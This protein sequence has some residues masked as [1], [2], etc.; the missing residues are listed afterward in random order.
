MWIR[1]R[2]VSSLPCFESS[3]TLTLWLPYLTSV[4]EIIITCGCL[5]SHEAISG[6]FLSHY[7]LLLISIDL[8]YDTISCLS[9]EAQN[10]MHETKFEQRNSYNI[11]PLKSQ[12]TPV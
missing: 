1:N 9:L 8:S 5:V 7:S 2:Y 6:Y 11:N 4:A 10:C 3:E 12:P